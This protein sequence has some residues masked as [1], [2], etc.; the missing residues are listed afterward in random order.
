M[1]IPESN[2]DPPKDNVFAYCH[3]CHGEI[4]EDEIY[5]D[6][7]G[8]Y[9]HE[10]CLRDFAEKHFANNR[11]EATLHK[12]RLNCSSTTGVQPF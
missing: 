11:R 9:I 1:Y 6:I 5:Y 2:L 4:Y 7:D 10:D 8:Q 12:W 3:Y